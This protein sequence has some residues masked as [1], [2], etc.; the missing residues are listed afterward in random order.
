[1][2]INKMVFRK[3]SIDDFQFMRNTYYIISETS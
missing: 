2:S 1:M 3:S